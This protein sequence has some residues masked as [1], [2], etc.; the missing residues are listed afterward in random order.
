MEVNN[1]KSSRAPL[2]YAIFGVAILI[3]SVA[4]SAYAYYAAMAEDTTA[5]QGSAAGAGV[6]LEV[7]KVSTGATGNLIPIDMTTDTLS[8]A[9]KGWNG[10]GVGTTWNAANACK[11]KNGYTVCQIYSVVVKNSSSNAVNYNIGVTSLTGSTVPNIEV[12]N[13]AS[14]ISVASATS[15]KGS[16]TGIASNVTVPANGSSSTYYIMVLI[17]NLTTA[18]DDKGAFNGVVTATSSYGN[19]LEATFA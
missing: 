8:K 1:L 3:V 4:G 14:N 13:M 11:D 9:A 7:T 19:K 2:M 17:K 18:Q 16:T 15:I 12:V 5:I 6:T 10:T